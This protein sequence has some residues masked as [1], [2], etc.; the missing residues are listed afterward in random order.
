MANKVVE[1]G[2]VKAAAETVVRPRAILDDH[3]ASTAGT[4]LPVR[5][6]Y[7]LPLVLWAGQQ[8]DL[9]SIYHPCLPPVEGYVLK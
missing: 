4:F 9:Q 5:T 2:R 1:G 7:Y 8:Q 6:A 3:L